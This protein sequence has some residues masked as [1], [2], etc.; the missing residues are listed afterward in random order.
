MEVC[1]QLR[2]MDAM[3][4]IVFCCVKYVERKD[5]GIVMQVLGIISSM[6][7]VLN[8]GENQGGNGNGFE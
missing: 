3:R 8:M 6:L 7:G 4:L 5:V 2:E 1:K